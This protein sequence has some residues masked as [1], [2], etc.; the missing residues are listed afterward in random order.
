MASIGSII[1]ELMVNEQFYAGILMN[2]RRSETYSLPTAAVSYD[3]SC[4]RFRLQYNPDFIKG[5]KTEEAIAVFQH[6]MMHIIFEHVSGRASAMDRH[7]PMIWNFATDL[8]INSHVGHK[9]H[10]VTVNK[11][12]EV[13][14]WE[15]IIP[16]QG[17][18]A[19]YPAHQS[20]EWYMSKILSDPDIK[21]IKVPGPGG[22]G[23][24][25]ENG[26]MVGDHSGWGEKKGNDGCGGEGR[27]P[28][29]KAELNRI[30]RAAKKE[31]MTRN[32]GS[33]P[34]SVRDMVA[35][36]LEPKID[37]T[38]VLRYF[39]QGSQRAGKYSTFKKYNKR[40]PYQQPGRRVRRTATIGI[41]IDQ[42]GSV[43]DELLGK[44]FGEL[45]SLS[46]LATFTVIP[47]D[48]VVHEDKIF[49]WKK[50][51]KKPPERVARG[52]T[53]F[54][55]PTKYVNDHNRKFDAHIILT[56]MGAPKPI[57]SLVPRLWITEKSYERYISEV[58]GRD[59]SVI[60]P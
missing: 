2:V 20:A 52:G 6:E 46:K 15:F 56:D 17:Q 37:W 44:F 25:G 42:S 18:W 36:M 50:G 9:L 22:Q 45:N 27:D 16:G 1:L 24:P 57:P 35:L 28:L 54:N 49:E 23:K 33:I 3:R 59:M 55:A 13:K 32:W 53:C 34:Q 60:I 21:K 7:G 51:Q 40:Y 31:A 5:M 48:Y 58:A 30:M 19:K 29:E 14:K 41:S 4:G 12:G 8:A 43:S 11:Q 47:F 39:V 38:A 26:D 10:K